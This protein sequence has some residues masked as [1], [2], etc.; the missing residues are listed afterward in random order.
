MDLKIGEE[1]MLVLDKKGALEEPSDD[2]DD[3]AA[4]ALHGRIIGTTD[5]YVTV[6]I[7][8]DQCSVKRLIVMESNFDKLRFHPVM[9]TLQNANPPPSA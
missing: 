6:E 7:M 4:R 3:F 1:V 9:P 8:D 5:Y 2:F